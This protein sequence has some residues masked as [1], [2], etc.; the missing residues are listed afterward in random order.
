MKFNFTGLKHIY[1]D[2][3]D[4]TDPT[5]AFEIQNGAGVFVFMMFLSKE[6]IKKNDKL[7]LYF[8]NINTLQNIKLYGNHQSGDF[9][10]YINQDLEELIRLELQLQGGIGNEFNLNNFLNNINNNIPLVLPSFTKGEILRRAWPDLAERMRDVVDD[11]D[12]T[13]L[14]GLKR[15]KKNTKARDKTLRKLYL[16]VESHD[17]SIASFIE[18]IKKKPFTLAWTNDPTKTPKTFAQLAIELS[19]K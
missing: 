16:Y 7:F 4:S 1:S 9:Y 2:A 6:E 17:N 19:G 5:I 10:A 13:I 15:L 12:K 11:A 3:L 18:E 8:R 14:I